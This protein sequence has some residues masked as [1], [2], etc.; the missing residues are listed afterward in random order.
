MESLM[1]AKGTGYSCSEA[2]SECAVDLVFCVYDLTQLVAKDEFNVHLREQ[3]NAYFTKLL[4][5]QYS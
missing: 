2:G 3:K 5:L 1:K 4:T